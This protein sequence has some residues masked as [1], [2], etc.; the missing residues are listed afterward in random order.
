MVIA[1]VARGEHPG[2]AESYLFSSQRHNHQR[3]CLLRRGGHRPRRNRCVAS[4]ECAEDELK[5]LEGART[6]PYTEVMSTLQEP[7]EPEVRAYPPDEALRRCRPLPRCEDLV[8]VE[9]PDDEWA[10]FQEALVET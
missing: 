1:K 4:S 3:G 7:E 8:V 2:E 9:A 5:D 6:A 10:A